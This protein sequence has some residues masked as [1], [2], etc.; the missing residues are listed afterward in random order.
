MFFEMFAFDFMISI[1][2][3]SKTLDIYTMIVR[4]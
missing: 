2:T 3:S 1:E 4:L